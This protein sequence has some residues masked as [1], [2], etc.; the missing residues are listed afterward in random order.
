MRG[1]MQGI[2]MQVGERETFSFIFKNGRATTARWGRFFKHKDAC[3]ISMAHRYE[4]ILLGIAD[5]F[6]F[7]VGL[8]ILHMMKK[9][10]MLMAMMLAGAEK[11]YS[12]TQNIQV[13]ANNWVNLNW[14]KLNFVGRI[15][16]WD[17]WARHLTFKTI[18]ASINFINL[19]TPRGIPN[20][21][22]LPAAVMLCPRFEC[23]TLLYYPHH[24]KLCNCLFF[25]GLDKRY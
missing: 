14:D 4:N 1:L 2:C 9:M 25:V 21:Q 5:S 13:N 6:F 20:H 22:V 3:H 7:V 8:K 15:H 17:H 11:L 16:R 18:R 24:L 23:A 10:L 12:K 19:N